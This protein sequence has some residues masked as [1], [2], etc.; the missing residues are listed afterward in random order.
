V[1]LEAKHEIE[2][3]SQVPI[4]YRVSF[5]VQYLSMNAKFLLTGV[6]LLVLCACEKH[7]APEKYLVPE[8][9]EGWCFILRERPQDEP[10]VQ[11]WTGTVLFDA[12]GVAKFS[13]KTAVGEARDTCFY[14]DKNGIAIRSV[15]EWHSIA[16]VDRLV[17]GGR[18]AYD[19]LFIG[20]MPAAGANPHDLRLEKLLSSGVIKPLPGPIPK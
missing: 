7:R 12:N 8:G 20:D 17:S 1:A 15:P 18:L 10:G 19:L 16:T 9:Y 4:R 5:G 2:A 3:D 14:V 13:G 6:A 11:P